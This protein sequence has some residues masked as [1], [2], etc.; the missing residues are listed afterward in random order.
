MY[1][2]E[3]RLLPFI[4]SG[5]GSPRLFTVSEF[6]TIFRR[7]F[8]SILPSLRARVAASDDFAPRIE[9][10]INLLLIEL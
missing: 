6:A 2:D 10:Q 7:F 8:L 9:N 5:L 4:S 1:A 3:E